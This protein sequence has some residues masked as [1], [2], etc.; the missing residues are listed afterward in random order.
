VEFKITVCDLTEIKAWILSWGAHAQV[1]GP[2]ELV[3]DM[4]E[5]LN[6]MLKKYQ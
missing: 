3:E 6:K 4:K 2:K 5:E 1:T